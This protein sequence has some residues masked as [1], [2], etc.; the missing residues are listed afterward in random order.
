MFAGG[1]SIMNDIRDD[2]EQLG[3]F[4]DA[5]AEQVQEARKT[6]V[7]IEKNLGQVR[8]RF[9]IL[10]ASRIDDEINTDPVSDTGID[11][12]DH[13]SYERAKGRSGVYE[14]S[15]FPASFPEVFDG[16]DSGFDVIVGNPPWE[17]AKIER[18]E[19]WRRHYPG[20]SGL[21]KT[22]VKRR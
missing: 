22:N 2:I 9:D 14:S 13:E 11:V 7:E 3:S 20:L 1:Q 12:R 18:D 15:P 4:A 10:A 17:Q 5:S 6:R 21:D 16:D 8:A 19:F